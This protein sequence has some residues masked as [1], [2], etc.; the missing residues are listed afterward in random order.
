MYSF[1][2]E[3]QDEDMSVLGRVSCKRN[4]AKSLLVL[5]KY[6]NRFRAKIPNFRVSEAYVHESRFFAN[7][8]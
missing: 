7:F 6:Q 3:L 8:V 2:D 5:R 1:T 4:L